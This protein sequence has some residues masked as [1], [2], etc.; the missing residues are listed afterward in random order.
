MYVTIQVIEAK[1]K[2][3]YRAKETNHLIS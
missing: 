3:I 2:M 1:N